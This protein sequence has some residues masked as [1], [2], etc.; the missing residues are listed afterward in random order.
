MSANSEQT[1]GFDA[2]ALEREFKHLAYLIFR[3]E[4]VPELAEAYLKA[5]TIV[6]HDADVERIQR[7]MTAAVDEGGDL[8]AVEIVL[9]TENKSNFLSQKMQ[10]LFYL[11]ETRPEY[12]PLFVNRKQSMVKGSI[13]LGLQALRSAYKLIKGHLLL[14]RRPYR[15]FLRREARP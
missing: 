3:V 8:E 2:K 10:I 9:R 13:L 11:M 15:E 12:F 6:F 4:P 7:L 5:N 14:R 1:A